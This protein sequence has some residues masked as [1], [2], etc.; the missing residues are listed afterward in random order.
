MSVFI[1][2][3]HCEWLPTRA[4]AWA[5]PGQLSDWGYAVQE[6]P[7]SITDG[8]LANAGVLIIGNAWGDLTA[9]EVK[10]IERFV[11]NGGGLLAAGLGWSW[12]DQSTEPDMTCAGQA[13]GQS[14]DDL[15]T[16]P[17]NRVVAPYAMSWSGEA[18]ERP[19]RKRR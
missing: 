18:I 14:I 17:M 12:V 1:A 6:I 15:R 5:L 16:Y 19:K 3:G 11:A 8:W 7:G 9:D 10:A 2:S 13:E 4:R